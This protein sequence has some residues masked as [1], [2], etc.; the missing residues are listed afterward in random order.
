LFDAYK[1]VNKARIEGCGYTFYSLSF[2]STEISFFAIALA[3]RS[4]ECVPFK[5][6]FLDI[7]NANSIVFSL[8]QTLLIWTLHGFSPMDVTRTAQVIGRMS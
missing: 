3:S 2:N 4:H 5:L 7:I 6:F 8:R 1:A